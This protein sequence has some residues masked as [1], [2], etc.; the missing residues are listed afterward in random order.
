M[1][2]TTGLTG[3]ISSSDTGKDLYWLI[4]TGTDPYSANLTI[5]TESFDTTPFAS[6]APIA[7][8]MI[9]GLQSWNGSFGARFPAGG[10]ASGHTGFVTFSS[11]YVTNCRGWSITAS[12]QSFE[13]TAQASTAPT[14]MTFTP[15]LYSFTGSYECLV[16]DTTAISAGASGSATFRLSTESSNDNELAG[17]IIV[18]GVAVAGQVGDL[19]RVTISFVVNGNLTTDG[20]SSFLEVGTPGTPDALVTPE[21]TAITIRAAGSRTYAGN[22]FLTGWTIG[23]R[24]GSSIEASVNFQGTGAL[25]IG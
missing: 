4:N 16:D 21:V 1:A 19:W 18:T 25:T 9:G 7:T 20:D 13:T 14:W 17:S 11:G 23:S 2:A 12:A 22:A 3:L 10:A 8:S 6:T 15:G 24:I 5:S